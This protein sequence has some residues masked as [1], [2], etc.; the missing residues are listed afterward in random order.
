MTFLYELKK[1]DN[2]TENAKGE[3]ALKSSLSKV[4]DLYTMIGNAR[5]YQEDEVIIAIDSAYKENPELTL[6]TIFYGRDIRE[7]GGDRDLLYYG[8]IYLLDNGLIPNKSENNLNLVRLISKYGSYKDIIKVL[9]RKPELTEQEFNIIH[10]LY[11]ILVEYTVFGNDELNALLVAKYLP[12]ESSKNETVQNAYK[13]IIKTWG[14][15]RKEYRKFV[16]SY[17]KELNLIETKLTEKD[18]NIDYSKVPSLANLKYSKAFWANDE[19]NYREFLEGVESGTKKM[20]TGVLEPYQIVG[21]ILSGYP[22]ENEKKS[23]DVM[24]NEMKFE[25]SFDVLPIVDVS[26][27]MY[28]Y[29]ELPISVAVSLGIYISENNEGEFKNH[30]ITFSEKPSLVEVTGKDLYE[31]VTNMASA[32][33]GMSTNMKSV[34]ELILRTALDKE[35]TQEDLPKSL[36]IISD[37]NM[38]YADGFS[39][40]RYFGNKTFFQKMKELYESH[41]YKLPNIIFWYVNNDTAVV[42]KDETNT[43]SVSGFSKNIFKTIL[44]LDLDDLDNYT[45]EKA[46]LET[47]N[48][49]RYDDVKNLVK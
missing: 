44:K 21:N 7:G 10:I 4:L 24:W 8:I 31:K 11:D 22:D 33:W 13:K 20:N 25:H 30:F 3:T 39:N 36:L 12:T 49:E 15:T 1:Q 37:M 35:M 42:D 2:Y 26:G 17:R 48:Q 5:F 6:R 38:D 28:G 47:L 9:G 41:G 18:Y 14:M 19:E 43:I 45:P 40:G 29:N 16:S 32:D 34:F 27:S 23:L 46:M